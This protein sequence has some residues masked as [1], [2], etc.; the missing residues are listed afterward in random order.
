MQ[1]LV[2]SHSAPQ[3]R[4]WG[5]HGFPLHSHNAY[6]Y[7]CIRPF[8][9]P[10]T[11]P[12]IYPPLFTHQPSHLFIF[13][14]AHPSIHPLIHPSIHTHIPMY[15]YI[16]NCPSVHPP[17]CQ[18]PIHPLSVHSPICPSTHPST[19]PSIYSFIHISVHSSIHPSFHPHTH[20]STHLSAVYG[21]SLTSLF[22]MLRIHHK[23]RLSHFSYRSYLL[24]YIT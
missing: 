21:A 15:T 22:L 19:H 17:I 3:T 8:V 6:T 14:Y 18:S 7:T 16:H 23:T 2:L 4:A 12:V 5:G 20:P 10:P 24:V 1:Q 13:P 11:C 9:H